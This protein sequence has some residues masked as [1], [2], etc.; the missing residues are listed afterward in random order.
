MATN[1]PE[2]FIPLRTRGLMFHILVVVF[3]LAG[4]A[5]CMLHSNQQEVGGVFV[6][7]LLLSLTLF[8]PVPLLIYRGYALYN[9]YYQLSRDGLRI[10]WG[11]RSEDIPL[12]DIEW[13]R[14]ASELGFRLPLPRITWPGAIRGTRHVPELGEVEFMASNTSSLMVIATPQKVYAISPD[15]PRGFSRAFQ[16]AMEM[17]SLSPL[18]PASTQAAA[19]ARRVWDDRPARGFLIAGLILTVALFVLV[20]MII[21]TRETISLGYDALGAPLPPVPSRQ[22][23]LLPVLGIFAFIANLVAGLYFYRRQAQKPVAFM[24]WITSAFIPLMLILAAFLL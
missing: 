5:G 6:L 9:A 3:L 22:L 19:Y 7:F 24:L 12:P 1:A 14:P 23:L 18:Q 16:Y 21:P 17:G 11:L 13:V 4:S 8:A 10:R 15:D 20:S 2:I